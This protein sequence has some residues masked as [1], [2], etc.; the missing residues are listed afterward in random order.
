M[1]VA[2][3][4][5]QATNPARANLVS[6]MEVSDAGSERRTKVAPAPKSAMPVPANRRNLIMLEPE[7]RSAMLSSLV[8]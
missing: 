2:K 3:I 8:E 6:M 5:A 7:V 1:T 4:E